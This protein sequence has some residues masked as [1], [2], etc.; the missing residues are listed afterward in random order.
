MFKTKAQLILNP[1]RPNL[2]KVRT[3][4]DSFLIG[5]VNWNIGVYYRYLFEKQYGFKL[6]T[7][8]FDLH[9][10]ILNGRQPLIIEESK[11]QQILS[12]YQTFEVVYTNELKTLADFVYLPVKPLVCNNIYRELGFTDFRDNYHITIGRSPLVRGITL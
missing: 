1:P 12:K 9:L 7:P 4:Q 3:Y 5:K 8:A 2:K 6:D 11:L 10:T